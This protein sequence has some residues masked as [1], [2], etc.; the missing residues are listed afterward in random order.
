M[1]QCDVFS[2]KIL[3]RIQKEWDSIS[4][5]MIDF[6]ISHMGLHTSSSEC[7][8]QGQVLHC[9]CRN[10]SYSSAKDRSSTANQGCSFTRDWIGAVA[11]RCFLHPTLSLAPVQ[12]LKDPRGSNMVMRRVD[13]ANWPLQNSQ[14]DLNISSIRV[15]DQIRDPEIQIT[16]L[17]ISWYDRLR[18][19]VYHMGL[20]T[21]SANSIRL[22][23]GYVE[24]NVR[25]STVRNMYLLRS[26]VVTLYHW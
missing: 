20:H 9:K 14:Q 25:S 22:K 12:T 15:F 4:L 6:G 11:S 1:L 18:Y 17:H 21:I 10:L 24:V 3:T 13:L 16:L 26:K 5:G 2:V 7:S 8:T 19:T 23:S